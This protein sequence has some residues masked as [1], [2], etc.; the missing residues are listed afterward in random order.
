[1][2]YTSFLGLGSQSTVEPEVRQLL[3]KDPNWKKW[4]DESAN[5]RT[6]HRP[7]IADRLNGG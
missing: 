6:M 3:S 7:T 5:L 1:M 4:M 2:D